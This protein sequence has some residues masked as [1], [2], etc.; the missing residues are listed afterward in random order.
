MEFRVLGPLEVRTERGVVALG[1][2]KPRG[3][4]AMLLLHA[5]QAI[6]AERLGLGL[7]GEDAPAAAGKTV[8]V[9]VARLRKAL[10]VPDVIATTPAGYRIDV[11][12][13]ELDLERFERLVA[14]GRSLLAERP[15]QAAALLREALGLWRGPPLAEFANLPFA[16]GEA[17][18][19]EERRLAALEARIEADLAAGGHAE[20]LAELERLIE[21]QPWR[22]RLH[23]QLMLALYRAG[24]QADA[25]AAYRRAQR[26]L[27]EALGLEP[28][29]ELRALEQAILAQDPALDA[30]RDPAPPRPVKRPA[31]PAPLTPMRGRDRELTLV[32]RRLA[33]GVRLLTLTGPGGV[34][35][36]RVAVSA[37]WHLD[38]EFAQGARFAALAPLSAADEVAGAIAA[39]LPIH[40]EPSEAALRSALGDEQLLLVVDNF[41]HVLDAAPLVAR[42]LEAAPELCVLATSR[43][44]LRIPG[45]HVLPLAPL[46]VPE[47]V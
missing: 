16:A 40:G 38:N 19:L 11:R 9:H 15:R 44:P 17:G 36:T 47:R 18:W 1:G 8:Q 43:E 23:W 14:E 46:A 41:E 21:E 3:V 29:P 13:G 7:W 5:N 28:T 35:K 34:G 10:G 33:E 12:S 2:S 6:D 37:A 39:T 42:L 25:L 32:E 20:V 30:P 22:E 45:E 31:L 4:L 24:R 27:D 26:A